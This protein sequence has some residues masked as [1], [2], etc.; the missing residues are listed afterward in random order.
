M[1]YVVSYYLLEDGDARPVQFSQDASFEFEHP[2]WIPAPGDTVS[3]NSDGPVIT[4]KVRT[5]HFHTENKGFY[6]V[7]IVVSPT[8]E[9]ELPRRIYNY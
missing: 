1:E 9:E 5:R 8:P 6:T 3:F 7:S 4:Y 2:S